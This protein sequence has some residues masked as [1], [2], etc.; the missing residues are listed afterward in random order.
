MCT[1]W[2]ARARKYTRRERDR[3]RNTLS[4]GWGLESAL[5]KI[6]LESEL[7]D[8]WWLKMHSWENK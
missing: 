2:Y 7:S 5:K 3:A 8:V 1:F 6:G 4:D